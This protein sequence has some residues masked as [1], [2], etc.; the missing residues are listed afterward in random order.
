MVWQHDNLVRGKGEG[1]DI[2]GCA[3]TGMVVLDSITKQ[4]PIINGTGGEFYYLKMYQVLM[5][6]TREF[7]EV[8]EVGK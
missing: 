4:E 8:G 2:V 7:V 6:N 5:L 3:I 1:I